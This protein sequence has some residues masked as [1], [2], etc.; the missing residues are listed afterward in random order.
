MGNPITEQEMKEEFIEHLRGMVDYWE[1]EE[2][3]PT[4]RA[5]LEG[6]AFS[7][8]ATLDGDDAALPGYQLMPLASSEEDKQYLETRGEKYYPGG[9]DISGNLHEMFVHR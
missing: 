6:L 1:K 2:R 4:S 9:I 3:T 5:K 8:L 7:I